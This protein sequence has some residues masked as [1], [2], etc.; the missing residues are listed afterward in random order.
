MG[1]NTLVDR[2]SSLTSLWDNDLWRL[3]S[4]D[5]NQYKNLQCSQTVR[6]HCVLTVYNVNVYEL[7]ICHTFFHLG[8]FFKSIKVLHLGAECDLSWLYPS[9]HFARNKIWTSDKNQLFL[10]SHFQVLHE[11]HK[12][13]CHSIDAIYAQYQWTRGKQRFVVSGKCAHYVWSSKCIYM[14]KQQKDSQIWHC[15]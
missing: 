14:T 2:F 10:C 6:S 8:L 13:N 9:K 11:S 3:K 12:S 5:R 1:G 15:Q 7:D 4:F